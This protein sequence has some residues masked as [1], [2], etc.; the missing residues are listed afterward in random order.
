MAIALC[1]RTTTIGR[2][3]WFINTWVQPAPSAHVA[4]QNLMQ[5]GGGTV[6]FM[7]V[8]GSIH[9]EWDP[10]HYYHRIRA[11]QKLETIIDC[12]WWRWSLLMRHHHTT[13]PRK[14]RARAI[15]SQE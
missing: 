8:G 3:S 12:V 1:D 13:T 7:Q 10:N 6:E 9:N 2:L 5:S 11:F 15:V 4:G 14:M